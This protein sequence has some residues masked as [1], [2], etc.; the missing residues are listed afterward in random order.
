MALNR[1]VGA[2]GLGWLNFSLGNDFEGRSGDTSSYYTFGDRQSAYLFTHGRAVLPWLAVGASFKLYERVLERYQA[3]GQGLDL[4]LLMLLGENVRLGVTSSDLFASLRWNTDFED[5]FPAQ[6]RAN[7]AAFGWKDRIT[8]S[9]QMESVEGRQLAL[10]AGAELRVFRA[11]SGRVGWQKDGPTFGGGLSLD[12]AQFRGQ[13]DYAFLPD[14]LRQGD[15]QR[16]S[17]EIY[18]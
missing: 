2:W 16:F 15:A 17:L 12:L 8:V 6:I 13:V 18:F 5:K 3:R 1:G 9:A 7:I 4:G 11:I 14:P 10:G